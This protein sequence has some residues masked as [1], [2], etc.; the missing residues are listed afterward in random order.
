MKISTPKL[1]NEAKREGGEQTDSTSHV[2]NIVD[3]VEDAQWYK[4]LPQ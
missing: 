2:C 4:S 1:A 3:L